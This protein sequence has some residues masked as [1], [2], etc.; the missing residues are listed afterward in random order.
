MPSYCNIVLYCLSWEVAAE[1][2]AFVTLL[3]PLLLRA[4]AEAA[5]EDVL[6]SLTGKLMGVLTEAER[7]L[8]V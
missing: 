3:L 7:S 1:E 2:N 8:E 5:E 4:E 6:Y